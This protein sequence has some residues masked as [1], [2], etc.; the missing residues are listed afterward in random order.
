M[1]RSGWIVCRSFPVVHSAWFRSATRSTYR[2]SV[3]VEQLAAAFVYEGSITGVRADIAF[4]QSVVET[5]W[6]SFP[7]G[8]YV[9]PGDN[10]FAGIGA[11]GDGSN[12][13]RSPDAGMGVN[14]AVGSVLE[15][16]ISPTAA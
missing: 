6:F 8:G 15:T 2:A 7:A 10:N 16:P 3:P 5:G 14:D 9:Q 1:F 13:M 12:L 11:Y 4:A